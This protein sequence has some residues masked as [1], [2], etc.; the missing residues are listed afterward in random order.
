MK[1]VYV[2]PGSFCPPTYGHLEIAKKAAKIFPEIIIVCSTNPEKK[3]PWFTAKECKEMWLSYNLPVNVTVKTLDELSQ[4]EIRA[5]NLVMIRGVRDD[6]DLDYE[7][8][9]LLFNYRNFGICM[10]LYIVSEKYKDIS[11]TNVR[12]LAENLE[13]MELGKQVSPMILTRLLE[14]VLKIKNLFIVAGKPGSG[15]STFL[16][17]LV[18][19]SKNNI[20]INTDQFSE[21]LKPLLRKVFGDEDLVDIAINHKEKLKSVIGPPWLEKAKKALRDTP[22]GSNVFLEIP[23]AFQQDKMSFRHFGGKIIYVNCRNQK[24]NRQRVTERGTPNIAKFVREIP[25]KTKTLKIA[26]KYKL[27]VICLDTGGSL[28]NLKKKAVR[29]NRTLKEV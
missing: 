2:Y 29:F 14:K 28:E 22:P 19:E 13:F 20:F 11:S 18:K 6:K 9:V 3:N 5:G 24:Q 1:S 8:R 25:G 10:Y 23:Y 16:N 27:S 12:R 17:M 15:K 26:K 4:E 7:K 21:E